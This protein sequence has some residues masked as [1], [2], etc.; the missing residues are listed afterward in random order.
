MMIEAYDWYVAH[1]EE[2]LAEKSRSPHRSALN[3]GVLRLV[4][5]LI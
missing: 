1:R 5:R 4:G 3:Q 2:I